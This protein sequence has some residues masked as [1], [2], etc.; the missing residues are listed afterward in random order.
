MSIFASRS[1]KTIPIPH[2]PPHTVTIQKLAGRHLY[3]ADQENDFAAQAYVQ[4]MGGAEFRQQLTEALKDKD[5]GAEIKKVQLDPVN[6]FDKYVVLK[7]GLKGWD[8]TEDDGTSI[9][10]TDEAIE[11]LEP[12]SVE[13]IAREILRYTKPSLFMT[14]EEAKA[15]Q[16]N[17]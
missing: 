12:E 1:Q 10:V 15:E 9:P 14:V 4:K 3:K 11:D 16:K 7:A 17:G 8:Y 6:A 2:D 5:P 13:Y